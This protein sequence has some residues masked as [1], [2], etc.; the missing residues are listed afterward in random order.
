MVLRVCAIASVFSIVVGDSNVKAREAEV[1]PSDTAIAAVKRMIFMA[2]PLSLVLVAEA[3]FVGWSAA[4]YRM[5]C[6]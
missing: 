4:M 5:K 1:A 3:D 2:C 6:G